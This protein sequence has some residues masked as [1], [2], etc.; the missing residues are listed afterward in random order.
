MLSDIL[1]VALPA[2]AGIVAGFALRGVVRKVPAGQKSW[3]AIDAEID[4]KRKE[5]K[6]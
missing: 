2:V 5:E 6:K 4:A 1:G 3:D